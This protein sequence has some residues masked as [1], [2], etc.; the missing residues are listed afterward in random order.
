MRELAS[1]VHSA[2]AIPPHG[3]RDLIERWNLFESLIRRWKMTGCA[4][5]VQGRSKKKSDS[6]LRACLVKKFVAGKFVAEIW[7]PET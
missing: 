2:F 1:K 7:S 6:K 3:R 4:L 5:E